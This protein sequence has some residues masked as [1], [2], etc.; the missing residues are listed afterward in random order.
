MFY[1][2]RRMNIVLIETSEVFEPVGNLKVIKCLD[3]VK[4]KLSSECVKEL[5]IHVTSSN[6][7]LEQNKELK[8]FVYLVVTE[9]EQ[10]FLNQAFVTPC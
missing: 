7:F 3:N 8:K 6:D 9:K 2:W 10:I 4:I 1:D 5:V